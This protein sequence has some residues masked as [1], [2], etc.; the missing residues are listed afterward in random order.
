MWGCE[1]EP[2]DLT[3]CDGL[4]RLGNNEALVHRQRQHE[5]VDKTEDIRGQAINVGRE[6]EFAE[7]E[8]REENEVRRCGGRGQV[9]S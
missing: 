5:E 7:V 2:A 9:E 1:H 6:G 3:L 4:W 8:R